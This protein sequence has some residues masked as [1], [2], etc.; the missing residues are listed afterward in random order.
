MKS[1]IN[2]VISLF[3]N[4]ACNQYIRKRFCDDFINTKEIY[5]KH[6]LMLRCQMMVNILISHRSKFSIQGARRGQGQKRKGKKK[7]VSCTWA[8]QIRL[9]KL[10]QIPKYISEKKWEKRQERSRKIQQE[11]SHLSKV[12]LSFFFFFSFISSW[13]ILQLFLLFLI[14]LISRSRS[15]FLFVHC[16]FSLVL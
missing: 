11:S 8:Q 3:L 4:L 2:D 14:S 13:G 12:Q 7:E 15:S 16:K 9:S 5:Q 10:L 6:L 1:V